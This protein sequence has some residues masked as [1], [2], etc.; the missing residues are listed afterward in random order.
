MNI[1]DN[2]FDFFQKPEEERKNASP[3]G[4]CNV[5]WGYQQYDGKIREIIKDKQ[6]DVNNHRDQY[7]VIQ[8]FV[9]EHL[10]GIKLKEGEVISCPTCNCEDEDADEETIN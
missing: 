7:L 4:L 2:I 8:D 10:E 5:C 9:K 1:I 3:E 6:I